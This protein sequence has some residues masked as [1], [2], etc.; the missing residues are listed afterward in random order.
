M[1][2]EAERLRD[3]GAAQAPLGTRLDGAQ[4]PLIISSAPS[5]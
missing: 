3:A 4:A 5:A 2:A 1:L